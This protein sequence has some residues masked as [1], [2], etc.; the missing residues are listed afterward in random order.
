[1][2][3]TRIDQITYWSLY[4][5]YPVKCMFTV[6]KHQKSHAEKRYIVQILTK[7]VHKFYFGCTISFGF[8]D[9]N[10]VEWFFCIAVY[11]A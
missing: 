8:T 9:Y 4:I 7:A 1:M 3:L 6:R 5:A 2:V 11:I 10:V